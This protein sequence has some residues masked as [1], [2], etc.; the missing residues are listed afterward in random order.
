MNLCQNRLQLKTNDV[1]LSLTTLN[2][3]MHY[4]LIIWLLLMMNGPTQCVPINTGKPT[5]RPSNKPTMSPSKTPIRINTQANLPSSN[6]SLKPSSIPSS[7]PF[8]PSITPS[9]KPT[10]I[11]SLIP[12]SPSLKPSLKPT[13]FPTKKPSFIPTLKPTLPVQTTKPTSAMPTL[14]PT[15]P[16]YRPSLNP[17]YSPTNL[18]HSQYIGCYGDNSDRAMEKNLGNVNSMFACYSLALSSGYSLYGLQNGTQCWASNNLVT[19]GKYGQCGTCTQCRNLGCDCSRKKCRNGDICG[20][21]FGTS[22]YQIP[23]STSN[24]FGNLRIFSGPNMCLDFPNNNQVPGQILLEWGC[25]AVESQR[26]LFV[27]IRDGVY[28]LMTS[29]GLCVDVSGASTAAGASI[30]LAVCNNQPSQQWVLTDLGKSFFFVQP[31]HALK[32]NMCL[33][34]KNGGSQ[35]GNTIDLKFCYPN[36]ASQSWTISMPV[37]SGNFFIFII[38]FN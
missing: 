30:Q 6:P 20:D 32:Q 23:T 17:T 7:I 29:Q 27:F 35:N 3:K 16:T 24:F 11:P 33:D 10:R 5:M 2:L 37:V 8:K 1:N 18:A 14:K 31:S 38:Y 19:A 26:F 21:E 9:S 28:K 15:A 25:T 12:T 36:P 22:L 34:N 13:M 4:L